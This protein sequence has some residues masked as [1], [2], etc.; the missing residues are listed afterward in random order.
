MRVPHISPGNAMGVVDKVVGLLREVMG[1]FLDRPT[2]KESGRLQQEKGSAKLDQLQAE[3][4]AETHKA[5]VRT[6]DK[7]QQKAA[8]SS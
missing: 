7:A 6:L 1:E 2:L 3:V 8:D 5:K 4:T